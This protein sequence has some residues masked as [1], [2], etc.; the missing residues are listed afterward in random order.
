MSHE[1]HIS[2]THRDRRRDPDTDRELLELALE[3]LEREETEAV[4]DDL[5]HAGLL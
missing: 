1:P 5:A 4:A 3:L 2:T